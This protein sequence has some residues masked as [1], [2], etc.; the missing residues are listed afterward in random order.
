[1]LDREIDG[2]QKLTLTDKTRYTVLVL[3]V[4]SKNCGVHSTPNSCHIIGCESHQP[5]FGV[6]CTPSHGVT[7]YIL[8]CITHQLGCAMHTNCS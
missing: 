4:H 1:M 5:K 8:V 6:L 3:Y 2:L 7:V